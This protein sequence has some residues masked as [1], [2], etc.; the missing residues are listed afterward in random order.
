MCEDSCVCQ[1]CGCG[2]YC[3]EIG[4]NPSVL[5][6]LSYQ[7]FFLHLCHFPPSFVPERNCIGFENLLLLIFAHK[8]TF[9]LNQSMTHCSYLNLLLIFA[10]PT[11]LS[12]PL[13][14]SYYLPDYLLVPSVRWPLLMH[15]SLL[16]F[17]FYVMVHS[18][19]PMFNSCLCCALYTIT[20]SWPLSL[21]PSLSI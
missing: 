17:C 11:L 15:K 10:C 12:H 18:L 9:V 4:K 6:F 8:P 19:G 7:I 2:C 3:H 16:D 1:T 20:L 14:I 13:L 21:P 5:P